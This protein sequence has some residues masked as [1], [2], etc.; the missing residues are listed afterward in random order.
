MALPRG[1]GRR[2]ARYSVLA[3]WSVPEFRWVLVAVQRTATGVDRTMRARALAE[4]GGAPWRL[5]HSRGYACDVIGT[6]G[7]LLPPG[8]A[9]V[10]WGTL[11]PEVLD[12]F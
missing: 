8:F 7:E 12:V 3:R 6:A 1:Y 10:I 5:F 2:P 4:F 11:C 9:P